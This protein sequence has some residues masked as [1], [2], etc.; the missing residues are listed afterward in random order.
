MLK[1]RTAGKLPETQPPCRDE[2]GNVIIN[3]HV[4]DDT[5]FLSVFSFS[6]APVISNE[7][8]E[9]LEASTKELPPKQGLALRIKSSCIDEDEKPIY[10]EA[11]REYYR[12]G[13]GESRRELKRNNIISLILAILGAVILAVAVFLEYNYESVIWAELV[14]IAAWVFVWEAVDTK[15][16]KTLHIKAHG[17]RCLALATMSI[18]F[19]D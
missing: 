1:E 6:D 12:K 7:V 14:D 19:Y 16:F 11:I 18:D 9:F 15:F 10:T 8:A 17:Q 3:M 4:K 13:Y 2:Q 5:N